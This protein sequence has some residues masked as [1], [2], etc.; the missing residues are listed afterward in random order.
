MNAKNC[1]YL[2]VFIFA[3]ADG[4]TALNCKDSEPLFF[5]SNAPLAFLVQGNFDQVNDH[6]IEAH[7]KER[8]S[9]DGSLFLEKSQIIIPVKISARGAF[10][11][12]ECPLRP[13]NLQLLDKKSKGEF[14]FIRNFSKLKLTTICYD[15]KEYREGEI[16]KLLKEYTIYK[17][18]NHLKGPHLQIRLLHLKLLDPEGKIYFEGPGFLRE[19][20]KAIGAR[21]GLVERLP[22]LMKWNNETRSSNR[23]MQ[24]EDRSLVPYVYQRDREAELR[25]EFIN[26]FLNNQDFNFDLDHNIIPLVSRDSNQLVE[27]S[28]PYDFDLAQAAG[29]TYFSQNTPVMELAKQTKDW[30]FNTQK[31]APELAVEIANEFLN[32]LHGMKMEIEKSPLDS[33]G[34]IDLIQWI[35]AYQKTFASI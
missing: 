35:D 26:R 8:A 4:H 10:R 15:Q 32:S 17:M 5:Q 28:I 29:A 21:C 1:V 13:F 20:E 12:E 24:L 11:F 23:W 14:P 3:I 6:T 22:T 9:S 34:K 7:E 27:Y 16:R 19:T 30:L 31:I 25:A 18:L 2:V 33:K